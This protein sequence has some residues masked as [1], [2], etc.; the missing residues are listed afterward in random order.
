M[1]GGIILPSKLHFPSLDNRRNTFDT[2]YVLENG[3]FVV[4]QILL[5]QGIFYHKV[6]FIKLLVVERGW[7]TVWTNMVGICAA[8]NKSVTCPQNRNDIVDCTVNFNGIAGQGGGW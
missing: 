1:Q 3:A 5:Q 6:V 8:S 4:D 2:S 7:G